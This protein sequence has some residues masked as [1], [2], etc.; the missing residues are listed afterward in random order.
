MQ[1]LTPVHPVTHVEN[2]RGKPSRYQ[3]E[4]FRSRA[5]N[6]I[7]K[8]LRRTSNDP[9]SFVSAVS[10]RYFQRN[11][12]KAMTKACIG[13]FIRLIPVTPGISRDPLPLSSPSLPF[14]S[15]SILLSSANLFD[16]ARLRVTIVTIPRARNR[17]WCLARACTGCNA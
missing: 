17:W 1:H 13:S 8:V 16:C 11:Y 9:F 12:R 6:Y 10:T 5:P 15:F 2:A 14:P 3:P 7:R 4:R